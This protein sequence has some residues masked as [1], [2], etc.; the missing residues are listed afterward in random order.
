MEVQDLLDLKKSA[1][2]EGDIITKKIVVEEGARFDGTCSM[3][4]KPAKHGESRPGKLNKQ[5]QSQGK[6]AE[7][8]KAAV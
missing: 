7:L 1:R 6:K 5:Q 8:H 2:I 3:G 4:A